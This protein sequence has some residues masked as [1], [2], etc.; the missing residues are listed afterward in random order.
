MHF[1][2]WSK[3]S[4]INIIQ[5][6]YSKH[7]EWLVP[8]YSVVIIDNWII[9]ET[10]EPW[11]CHCTTLTTT[12]WIRIVCAHLTPSSLHIFIKV[13]HKSYELSAKIMPCFLYYFRQTS[14]T[15]Q[16]STGPETY[17]TVVFHAILSAKFKPDKDTHVF[18]QGERPIFWGWKKNTI[19]LTQEK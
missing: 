19:E 4:N 10:N 14:G 17:L 13:M 1:K 8:F 18:I 15:H 9:Y 11:M 2:L 5:Y 16:G 12:F 7:G 3:L 6:W